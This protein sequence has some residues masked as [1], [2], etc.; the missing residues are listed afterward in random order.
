MSYVDTNLKKADKFYKLKEFDKAN[1]FYNLVLNKFPKNTRALKGI[2]LIKNL[3][4]NSHSFSNNESYY[5]KELL[6]LYD[7][8]KYLE[9][10]DKLDYF[11][12]K[13]TLKRHFIYNL[14]GVIYFNLGRSLN[15]VINLKRSIRLYP[16]NYE[17]YFNLGNVLGK[18][19]N[20]H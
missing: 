13:V 4:S 1:D 18:K 10:I 19:I 5:L 9:I 11:I 3:K 6:S 14:V 17:A 15:A 16:E 12:S 8:Q 2:N 20:Y 7:Q